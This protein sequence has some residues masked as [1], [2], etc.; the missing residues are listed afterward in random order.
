[1]ERRCA[2]CGSEK[3]IDEFAGGTERNPKRD[4]YC[5]SCRA[6][7]GRAHYV[8]NRQRCARRTTGT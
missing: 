3:P 8:A 6:E 7:Y 4:C 5:R 1:M 2:R